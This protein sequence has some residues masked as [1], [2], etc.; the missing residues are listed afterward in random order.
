MGFFGIPGFTIKGAGPHPPPGVWWVL[1]PVGLTE[2]LPAILQ[3]SGHVFAFKVWIFGLGTQLHL[4]LDQ[5]FAETGRTGLLNEKSGLPWVVITEH[6]L[7][8]ATRM[9]TATL[10]S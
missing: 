10:V 1:V 3:T 7:K 4:T 6:S 5:Y 9:V 2:T 8:Q